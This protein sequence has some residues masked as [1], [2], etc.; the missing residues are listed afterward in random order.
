MIPFSLLFL[1]FNLSK[2]IKVSATEFKKRSGEFIDRSLKEEVIIQKRKRPVAVVID[3]ERYTE[4]KRKLED[5]EDRLW[6]LLAEKI[7]EDAEF[8]EVDPKDLKNV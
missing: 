8:I 2:M 5:L 7:L 4:L 1:I 3:Y 6:A